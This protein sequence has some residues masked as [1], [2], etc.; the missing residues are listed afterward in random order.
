MVLICACSED[1]N[2]H[3]RFWSSVARGCE[4][5][6]RGC[7]NIVLVVFMH[8]KRLPV[9]YKIDFSRAPLTESWCLP[10]IAPSVQKLLHWQ[11]NSWKGNN[12]HV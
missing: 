5:Q 2:F 12:Y 6:L 7:R 4:Y 9:P 3:K 8:W 11:P 10:E 1:P